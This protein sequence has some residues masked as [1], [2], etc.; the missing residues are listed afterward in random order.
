MEPRFAVSSERPEKQVI[1]HATPGLVTQQADSF[2]FDKLVA[3]SSIMGKEQLL[4]IKPI[5]GNRLY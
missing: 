3:K 1:E 5:L 4:T 2:C